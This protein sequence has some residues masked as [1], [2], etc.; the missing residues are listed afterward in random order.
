MLIHKQGLYPL[1]T[2]RSRVY[3]TDPIGPSKTL[4]HYINAYQSTHPL[5]RGKRRCSKQAGFCRHDSCYTAFWQET[6]CS[7]VTLHSFPAAP[8]PHWPPPLS[9]QLGKADGSPTVSWDD[10]TALLPCS[11]LLMPSAYWPL[12]WDTFKEGQWKTWKYLETLD[13]DIV[14]NCSLM[15]VQWKR[16]AA[17]ALQPSPSSLLRLTPCFHTID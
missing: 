2:K 14:F 1:P 7:L 15:A 3:Y 8:F 17:V 4:E 10:C 5:H 13:W 6:Q 12:F 9:K 16:V 11:I